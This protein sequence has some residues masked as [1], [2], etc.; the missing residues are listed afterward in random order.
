MHT[1]NYLNTFIEVAEDCPVKAAE[2]PP[3]KEE[4]LPLTFSSI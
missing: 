4:F 3:V 1:T 2:I